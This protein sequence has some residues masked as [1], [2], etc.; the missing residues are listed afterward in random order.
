MKKIFFLSIAL[1]F[2]LLSGLNNALA[3]NTARKVDEFGKAIGSGSAENQ[4]CLQMCPGYSSSVTD[5][6]EGFE[7]LTCEAANCA[8]YRKCEQSPCAPGYDLSLK[9]CPIAVQPG[10]YHC[11]KCK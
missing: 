6:P 1:S 10:T 8:E 7:L 2:G 5:C 4:M 9:D 11:S 3:Q